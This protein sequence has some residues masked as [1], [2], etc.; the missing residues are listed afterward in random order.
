MRDPR[1]ILGHAVS[2]TRLEGERVSVRTSKHQA[3]WLKRLWVSV[4]RR[5]SRLLTLSNLGLAQVMTILLGI[6]SSSLWA[7]GVPVET[8]GQY[9]VIMSFIAIVG[10]YCLPGLGESLTIS[11]AK[12]YDGNLMTILRL[13]LGATFVGSLVLVG[14][15][16]FYRARQPELATGVFLAALLFPLYQLNLVW[17]P[18][19]IG[20]DE[21]NRRAFLT[22]AGHLLLIGTLTTLILVDRRT[23]GE[24]VIGVIAI[25]IYTLRHRMNRLT[26]NDTIKYGFHSSVA[27]LFDGLLATDKVIINHRLS[28]VDVAIYSIALVFSTQAKSVYSIFN[29]MI[30]PRIYEANSV[31]E[32]WSYLRDKLGLL[33]LFFALIGTAGFVT[34]PIL[35]PLLFSERYAVAA[36]YGKWLWLGSSVTMPAVYL[37]NILRA[38]KKIK[39]VYALSLGYPVFLFVLF[40]LFVQY[41]V[42]GI[43]AARVIGRIALAIFFVVSF[44]YYLRS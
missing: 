23:L 21:L 20:R 8:Y 15:G 7:R 42:T 35:V 30:T 40:L 3:L 41:G 28:A 6:L 22:T 31:A 4:W 36:P 14:V 24:L 27:T 13:K 11:A 33:T 32:A 2:T 29:Q 43:V 39:F 12:R 18:W 34:I 17:S 44:A 1:S 37:A 10:A 25:V 19:L 26:H 16:L 9:Q 38:Q 5:R